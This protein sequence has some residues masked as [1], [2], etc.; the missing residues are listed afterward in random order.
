VMSGPI[1]E[2]EHQTELTRR[3]LDRTLSDLHRRLSPRYQLQSAW[4]S[5]RQSAI[6]AY[7]SSA[8]W[9]GCHPL[10][11]LGMAAVGAGVYLFLRGRDK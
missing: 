1:D 2:L 4:E 8:R 11:V 7:R 5:T 9:A 10:R 3:A 6:R